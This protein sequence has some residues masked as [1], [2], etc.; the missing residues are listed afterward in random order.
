M[1]MTFFGFSRCGQTL[2]EGNKVGV[3]AT[4]HSG[5]HEQDGADVPASAAYRTLALVFPAITACPAPEQAQADYSHDASR[6]D[7]QQDLEGVFCPRVSSSS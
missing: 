3:V 1:R 5:D 2:V 7:E 6:Q 4:H